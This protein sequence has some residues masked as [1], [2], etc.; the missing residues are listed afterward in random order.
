MELS[1]SVKA[2]KEGMINPSLRNPTLMELSTSVKAFNEGISTPMSLVLDAT[3]QE[4]LTEARNYYK[5]PDN[6][7]ENNGS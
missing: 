1:K 3:P 6:C 4:G 7:L 2:F 5:D